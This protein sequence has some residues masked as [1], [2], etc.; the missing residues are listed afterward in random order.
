MFFKFDLKKVNTSGLTYKDDGQILA[1]KIS[2]GYIVNSNITFTKPYKI[3]VRASKMISGKRIQS[4]KIIVFNPNVTLLDAIKKASKV[5][6]NLMEELSVETYTKQEFTT[7]MPYS[8]VY[9]LYLEYKVAQ[10]E[11][12]DDKKEFSRKKLEQF[13]NKWLQSIINKPIGMIDEEDIHKIVS[14]I[15][16]A[17]LAERTSRCVYQYVNPVFK[18]FNM[19][20]A[21][22]GINIPSPALQRDLP[23]LNNERGL[24]LSLDEIKELFKELKNYPITPVREIFMFLMHGRRFGEV[25]TLEWNNINFE[26][27]TYTIRA[28]NNKARIDMIYHLSDRLKE[29]LCTMGIKNSGY[30][31]TKINNKNEPYS[32]STIRNHWNNKPIVIHQIRNCIATYLK[33]GM[34]IGDDIAGAIL[35]HK[36][37]KTITSRYG[38]INYYSF[39]KVIDDMLDEIFDEQT[40]KP[41]DNEKLNQLKI[42]FPDKT[43]KELIEVLNI[44][45]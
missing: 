32:T 20:A 19:K 14:A 25:V 30:V 21:K 9:Q 26:D 45:K 11:A 1:S 38:K 31:F 33:N 5:Y 16:K 22:F 37:N 3:Q 24:E 4:K 8:K 36:Q 28:L 42:L 12:R 23:P 41:I 6:E 17:G 10:Y 40:I 44:L 7:N 35:G 43:E 27:N 29:S 13:H 18:Y 39:G 34:G 15:K 2:D